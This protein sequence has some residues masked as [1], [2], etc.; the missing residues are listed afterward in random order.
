MAERFREGSVGT[1]FREE[2]NSEE[3]LTDVISDIDFS[4][5]DNTGDMTSDIDF[6]LDND[7]T[8]ETLTNGIDFSLS[9]AD[10]LYAKEKLSE[11]KR[12]FS[13]KS[14]VYAHR[15]SVLMDAEQ[16]S[17]LCAVPIF[18]MGLVS[19]LMFYF[20]LVR[21]ADAAGSL[22]MLLM[23]ICIFAGIVPSFIIIPNTFRISRKTKEAK[24]LDAEL[25]DFYADSP[26]TNDIPYEFTDPYIITELIETALSE[27][28]DN[29]PD[30]E[31]ILMKNLDDEKIMSVN[32]KQADCSD[33][34]EIAGRAAALYVLGKRLLI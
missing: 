1:R 26:Y 23:L 3:R 32:K 19:A 4:L 18:I 20:V 33:S 7:N 5:D 12:Y 9:C 30:A 2:E 17:R 25:R 22:A 27:D 14:S 8:S 10:D 16:L 24:L 29:I 31:Y 11:I 28:V 6:S 21:F 13:E 15:D 34:E